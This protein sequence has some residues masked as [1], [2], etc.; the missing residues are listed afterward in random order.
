[1]EY[2]LGKVNI[3]SKLQ[4][5]WMLAQSVGA[6]EKLGHVISTIPLVPI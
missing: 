2:V 4:Y 6:V 3:D 1:M 5:V